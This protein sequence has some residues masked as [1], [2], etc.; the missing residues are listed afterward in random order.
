MRFVPIN[1]KR[2]TELIFLIMEYAMYCMQ[3]NKE[4]SE[5][6]GKNR[7]A[8][9]DR[10]QLGIGRNH[11]GLPKYY[12]IPGMEIRMMQL[13]CESEKNKNCPAIHQK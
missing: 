5:I 3:K 8:G 9:W 12:W 6:T 13:G 10:S 4:Y 2:V 11:G 7:P 1:I